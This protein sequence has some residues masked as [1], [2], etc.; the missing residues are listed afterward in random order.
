MH[1]LIWNWV[2][3]LTPRE[4]NPANEAERLNATM[5]TTAV[6][7][8]NASNRLKWQGKIAFATTT[9]LSLGL[10]F[11]PLMQLANVPLALKGEVLNAIQI[12]L[13]VS[14]LV[15][16]VIIGTARYDV[17]SE[18]LNDCGDKLKELIRELRREQEAAGDKLDKETIRNLQIRYSAI[19]TDVENHTRN[20]YRLT[21]LQTEDMYKITGTVRLWMWI[22]YWAFS[23]IQHIPSICLLIVELIFIL[24]MFGATKIF[25][26]FLNGTYTS[27]S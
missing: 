15:Y 5:K 12:F 6:N 27:N 17:R 9:I 7:R 1:K 26:P 13:A 20:D 21:L 19:T 8:Y 24:D 10:I 2:F 22:Q 23:I 4:A 3:S 25:S 18:Q 11:I 16:S 14:I